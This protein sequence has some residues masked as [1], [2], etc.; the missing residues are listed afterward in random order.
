MVIILK[1]YSDRVS[2]AL[3]WKYYKDELCKNIPLA[4][5]IFYNRDIFGF[6][7]KNFPLKDIPFKWNKLIKK[8]YE[9]SNQWYI[10][11]LALLREKYILPDEILKLIFNFWNSLHEF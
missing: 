7:F 11:G 8:E 6:K 3:S 9:I 1:S 10:L 5:V 2:I 4:N